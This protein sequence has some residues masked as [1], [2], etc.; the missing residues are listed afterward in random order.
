[1]RSKLF[2]A[3]IFIDFQKAYDTLKRPILW[4]I[5]LECGVQGKTFKNVRAIYNSVQSCVMCKGELTNYFRCMQGLKQGCIFSP[6][7]FSLLINE[8]A[9]NILAR[10]KHGVSFG[11][12][13]I[14]L[15]ILLFADDLTL[16]AATV[17]GLQNQLNL[18]PAASE[19]L[20]LTINVD[21][22][23]IIVF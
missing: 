12:S 21:K 2:V 1:M 3:Y 6:V 13:E 20:G 5:L 19:R 23:K 10:A 8:L 16:I 9:N 7:L 22:S 17:T 14:E 15:V 4:S 18:L 11:P